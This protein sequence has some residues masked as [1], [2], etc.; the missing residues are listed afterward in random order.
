VSAPLDVK[1]VAVR[2]DGCFS[3]LLWEGRPFA[4]S[5]E[6][7]FDD[8]L[9]IINNGIYPCKRSH[10]FKGNYP[11]FEIYVPGHHRILFHKGNIETESEACIIVGESFGVLNGTTAVLDSKGGFTELMALTEGRDSFN[12]RVSGR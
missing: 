6:R 2:D 11:T 12:M 9:P 8:G 7:T 4:V 5:V 10:Y 3:A 1:T